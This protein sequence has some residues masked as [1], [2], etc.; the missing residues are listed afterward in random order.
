MSTP[1]LEEVARRSGVSRSTVSR[2]INDHPHVQTTTR[3]RVQAVVRQLDFQPNRAA[4][5]LAQGR[6]RT[7]GLLIPQGVG[8]LFTDPYFPIFVQGV[9]AACAAAEYAVMLWLAAPAYERQTLLQMLHG[10]QIDGVIVSSLLTD[11]SIIGALLAGGRPF[12]LVGRHD[13]APNLTYVDV[14]NVTGAHSIVAHLLQLGRRRVAHIAGPAT[15][16]VG[17]DRL[18]G[19][20]TALRQHG[21]PL[22][23]DLVAEGDFSEASGY[24]A[25]RRLLPHRPDA[26]F[27][28]S[29]AMAF[30][31][32]RA[33][34]AAGRA[35]P[36]DVAVAGF[37]DLPAAAFCQPPL[38][39]VRQ[40][41][42]QLA[43]QAVTLL[44]DQLREPPS[45]ARRVIL[46]GELIIRQS[47]GANR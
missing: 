34:Q 7:L 39:T 42:D 41:I 24:A 44:L 11:N 25:M 43:D 17:Q 4:R 37:D 33:L 10:G 6:S 23:P 8:V 16:R 13:S 29:D 22:T 31:A 36:A 35:V 3:E 45:R 30:G 46:P 5:S 20:T 2:V 32:L 47:C 19:Y 9:T 12:V 21:L 38:T 40:P 1:T 26:V 15:M 28:A 27:A 18:R 14:D